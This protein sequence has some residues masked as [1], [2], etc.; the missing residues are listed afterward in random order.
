MSK[1]PILVVISSSNLSLLI[2]RVIEVFL[3]LYAI[4]S[5]AS[6]TL[7]NLLV[8]S[9]SL[10][11]SLLILLSLDSYRVYGEY[12]F[13]STTRT[14]FCAYASIAGGVLVVGT[15]SELS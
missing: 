6:S 3:I 13:G 8:G 9:F 11:D 2:S 15:G 10:V 1:L 4:L 5:V 14:S 7:S 12:I